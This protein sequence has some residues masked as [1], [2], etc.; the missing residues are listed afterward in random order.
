MSSLKELFHSAIEA[1]KACH[2]GT[3]EFHDGASLETIQSVEHS[4]G[5]R[6][7]TELVEF[8][9]LANGETA[10]SEGLLSS[11]TFRSLEKMAEIHSNMLGIEANLINYHAE[12]RELVARNKFINPERRWW[13]HWIPIGSTTYDANILFLD[14]EPFNSE[15]EMQLFWYYEESDC[16]PPI[17]LSLEDFFSTIISFITEHGRCPHYTKLQSVAD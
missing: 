12:E 6:F 8:F 11:T 15:I 16:G 5:W 17:A 7:P 13:R 14:P 3:V 4:C 1:A 9:Q 2:H 10:N